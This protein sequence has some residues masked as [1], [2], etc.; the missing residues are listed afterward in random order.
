MSP[1]T[2]RNSKSFVAFGRDDENVN[3]EDSAFMMGITAAMRTT[4]PR[5]EKNPCDNMD[6]KTIDKGSFR[7]R[8]HK[9]E[10]ETLQKE[11]EEL[12]NE[13]EKLKQSV[14][15]RESMLQAK[16]AEF[17]EKIKEKEKWVAEQKRNQ[18][19]RVR[20][21]TEKITAKLGMNKN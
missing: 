3:Q 6:N 18:M 21:L 10:I 17:A 8:L 20:V 4:A 16:E 11:K 13:V 12:A 15:A 5:S 14:A 2:H 19:M 9:E 7:S 1:R